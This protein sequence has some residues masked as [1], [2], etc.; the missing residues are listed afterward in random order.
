MG[1]D[2]CCNE[3]PILLEELTWRSTDGI[4]VPIPTLPPFICITGDV[5]FAMTYVIE[6][7]LPGTVYVSCPVQLPAALMSV[8]MICI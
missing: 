3:K 4:V 2:A 7:N 8:C 1:L 6:L 5:P